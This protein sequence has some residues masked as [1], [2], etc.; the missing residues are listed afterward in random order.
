[1]WTQSARAVTVF[2]LVLGLAGCADE[3]VEQMPPA[4][5][6]GAADEHG[7]ATAHPTEGPRGGHLIELGDEQYHVELLH[8]EA[9]HTVTVHLLDAAGKEPVATD[10]PQIVLQ[11]F[12]D[13]Q[14]VDYALAAV[15][16]NAGGASEFRLVDE[17][18]VDALLHSPEVRGRMRVTIGGNE[19]T[20]MID[21]DAHADGHSHE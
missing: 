5:V 12:Q 4:D 14:F 9:S 6:H 7:H 8:D 1:M 11:L 19:F 21:H 18:L 15:P 20:G 2:A 10:Q 17:K 16:G 13:G 3:A